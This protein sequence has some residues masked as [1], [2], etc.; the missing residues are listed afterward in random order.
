MTFIDW[1]YL[2]KISVFFK[3]AIQWSIARPHILWLSKKLWYSRLF[4]DFRVASRPLLLKRTLLQIW[5]YFNRTHIISWTWVHLHILVHKI[6]LLIV[7]INAL[8]VNDLVFF[9]TDNLICNRILDVFCYILIDFLNLLT[10]FWFLFWV[11]MFTMSTYTSQILIGYAF[12]C[13]F[14]YFLIN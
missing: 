9:F 12:L 1:N 6:I 10:L 2:L 5:A 11:P 8:L 14:Y 3:W 4:N 13:K 7:L